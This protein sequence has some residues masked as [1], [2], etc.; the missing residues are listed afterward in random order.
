MELGTVTRIMRFP[1]KSMAGEEVDDVFISYSGVTGDRVYA[2]LDT[3]K[4]NNFPWMTARQK[5]DLVKY[6]TKFVQPSAPQQQYP[7]KEAF[8]IQVTT[9]E[10]HTYDVTDASLR[11]ALQ[12]QTGVP[13]QLRF[14]EAGMQD[15]RPLSIV[16]TQTLAALE[17]EMGMTV[18]HRRFRMNLEINWKNEQPYY[19]NELLGKTLRI[20]ETLTLQISKRDTRCVIITV[21]P[22]TGET[23]P[24]L[25]QHVAKEHKGSVGVYAVVLREGV[26]K[27]GDRI[28]LEN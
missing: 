24:E 8:T 20:G 16:S 9:P 25:L 13:L 3:T 21:D 19:E 18:D 12:E 14:S 15:S 1:V 26:V 4:T 2:F 28:V 11:D 6:R 5:H 23:T 22:D 27:N 7:R 17:Q 10:G